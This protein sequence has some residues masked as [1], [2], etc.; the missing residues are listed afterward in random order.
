MKLHSL[1]YTLWLLGNGLVQGNSSSLNSTFVSGTNFPPNFNQE[2]KTLLEW[3][4][5]L[6]TKLD[7]NNISLS[8]KPNERFSYFGEGS[9]EM[10]RLT[11]VKGINNEECNY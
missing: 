4:E 6:L 9:I 1:V 3:G 5:M 7:N 8:W 10:T 11:L 2:Q